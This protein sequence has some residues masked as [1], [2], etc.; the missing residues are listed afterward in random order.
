[1]K[2]LIVRHGESSNNVIMAKIFGANRVRLTSGDITMADAE[3]EWLEQ[4][5]DDPSVSAKGFAEAQ[6]FG[7]HYAELFRRSGSTPRVYCSPFLRT[8]QTAQ[9]FATLTGATVVLQP[10]IFEVG[11]VYNIDKATGGRGGPGECLTA[12]H[13][14]EQYPGYDVAKLPAVGGWYT[15]GYE[16]DAMAVVRARKVSAWLRSSALRAEVGDDVAVLVVHGAFINLLL[17]ELL[18]GGASD[19]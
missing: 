2:L 1:M 10:D 14:Q 5:S 9:P 4:R 16:T 17:L 18:D 11:G 12:A 3:R 13:I 19:G 15:D 6:E 7:N 8:L